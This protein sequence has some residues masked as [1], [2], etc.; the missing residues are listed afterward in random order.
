[1]VRLEVRDYE[2]LKALAAKERRSLGSQAAKL[3][4]EKL[5]AVKAQRKG[6]A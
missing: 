2:L 4:S 1:M 6:A 3:I 5:A